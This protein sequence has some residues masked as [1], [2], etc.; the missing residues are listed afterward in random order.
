MSTTQVPSPIAVKRLPRMRRLSFVSPK[1]ARLLTV[2]SYPSFHL[3]TFIESQPAITRFC[4]Y[5]GYVIVNTQ[6]VLATF[7]VE[8]N[9]NQQFLVLDD[10]T[11][12]QPEKP[13][14][15][16]SFPDGDVFVVTPAWLMARQQ[17]IDNWQLITPYITCNAQRLIEE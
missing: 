16:P 9:D 11:D 17:W 14:T 5:P 1:L 13:A 15:T 3:G 6:P 8:G 2:F 12:L 10:A 4:E 7:Y